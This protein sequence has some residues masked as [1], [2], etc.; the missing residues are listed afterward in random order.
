MHG[1]SPVAARSGFAVTVG[2]EPSTQVSYVGLRKMTAVRATTKPTM[3]RVVPHHR[4][5]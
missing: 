4:G 3:N 2:V 5:T 1:H